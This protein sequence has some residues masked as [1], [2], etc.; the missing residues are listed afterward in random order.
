MAKLTARDRANLPDSAFA[1]VDSNGKRQLPINDEPHVKN[2]LA[3]FEQV[4]FESDAAR[5]TARRRLLRAAKKYGI[6]PIGFMTS[7]LEA[8]RIQGQLEAGGVDFS[9][10]P[11]G[12]IT[13][14]FTD[15]EGSTALLRRLGDRYPT[16]LQ[17]AREI[18]RRH[19]L[20]VGGHVVEFRADET[21]TVFEDP[22]AAIN[23][24]VDIQTVIQRTGWPHQAD[25]R[26]RIGIHT[27]EATI[28]DTG[29]VGLAVHTAARVC[30][31]GHGGQI[32]IT[33]D[34]RTAGSDAIAPGTTLR[35]IGQHALA[36]QPHP[37][38]LFQVE[39]DGLLTTFPPPRTG[40]PVDVE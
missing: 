29:Y 19:T 11:D 30:S 15:I 32:I 5:D 31:A 6:V 7:Q 9:S 37:T 38:A 14:V 33:A 36:G 1:Y 28:T 21:F 22:T 17:Q 2:A 24:A 13:L 25:L 40:T 4:K 16:L 10:L 35:S 27:G 39:A 8:K 3:R 34:T 18:I 26:L 20:A 23:A 12:V